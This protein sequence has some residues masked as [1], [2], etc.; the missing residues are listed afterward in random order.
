MVEKPQPHDQTLVHR[1]HEPVFTLDVS[2]NPSFC[3]PLTI[4]STVT[5]AAWAAV[6]SVKNACERDAKELISN[7]NKSSFIEALITFIALWLLN[8]RP[9]N[10]EPLTSTHLWEEIFLNVAQCWIKKGAKS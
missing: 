5:H 6:I 10:G 1:V 8:V 9:A 7:A 2:A 3:S 4:H